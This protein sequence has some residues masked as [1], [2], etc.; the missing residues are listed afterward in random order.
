MTVLKCP[1]LDYTTVQRSVFKSTLFIVFNILREQPANPDTFTECADPTYSV[2]NEICQIDTALLDHFRSM[3]GWALLSALT[4]MVLRWH[5]CRCCEQLWKRAGKP[6]FARR[7]GGLERVEA[8]LTT[9]TW[10]SVEEGTSY[11]SAWWRFSAITHERRFLCVTTMRPTWMGSMD[12]VE[13]RGSAVW[14]LWYMGGGVGETIGTW[15]SRNILCKKF[16]VVVNDKSF[17]FT[18]LLTC[19]GS[20][21]TGTA[22]GCDSRDSGWTK[23]I[24]GRLLSETEKL[25]QASFSERVVFSEPTWGTHHLR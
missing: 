9:R 25:L 22:L 14:E 4:G 16:L 8:A 7:G 2:F 24:W 15:G 23:K 10:K 3:N 19:V 6:V 11:A 5:W 20:G 1:F 18:Q 12:S 21:W 17:L 13:G